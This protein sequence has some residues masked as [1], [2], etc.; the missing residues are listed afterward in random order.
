MERLLIEVKKVL[1]EKRPSSEGVTY[2][3][4]GFGSELINYSLLLIND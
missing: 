1:A 3:V 2:L 4:K